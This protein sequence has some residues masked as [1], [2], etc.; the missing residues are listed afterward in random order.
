MSGTVLWCLASRLAVVLSNNNEM[1]QTSEPPSE[2]GRGHGQC[3]AG[4]HLAL[5]GGGLR[6]FRAVRGVERATRKDSLP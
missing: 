1:P 6:V 4:I 3:G 5:G 2:V